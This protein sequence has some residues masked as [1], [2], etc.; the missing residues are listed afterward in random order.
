MGLITING[1]NP[2]DG[3]SDPYLSMDSSISYDGGVG[4]VTN[5]YSLQGALTGCSKTTLM[6]LQ[7][8]LVDSFDWKKDPSIVNNISISGVVSASDSVQIVP[9]SLSFDSSNYIGALSYN[10]SLDLITGFITEDYDDLINKTHT[11]T[12]NT[13]EKGCVSISTSISCTPNENLTGCGAIEAANAW[14][15]GQLG[16]TKLGKITR[17]KNM[18]LKSE[19]LTIDPMVSSISYNSSHAEKCNDQTEAG[20]PHSGYQ[21]AYCIEENAQDANCPSGIMVS[22]Y[23]GE[24]YKSG[25]AESGLVNHLQEE[26]LYTVPEFNN[27]SINYNNKEDNIN[28]SFSTL[29]LSGEPVYQPQDLILNNYSISQKTN[30]DNDEKSQSINGTISL[31]NSKDLD[32]S[33]INDK[34]DEEVKLEAISIVGPSHKIN[35]SSITRNTGEGTIQ[36]SYE[37]NSQDDGGSNHSGVSNYSV[38]YTPPIRKYDPVNTLCDPFVV[39]RGFNSRGDVSITVSAAS[40]S[41]F[42]F[43]AGARNKMEDLKNR[44]NPE[45]GDIRVKDENEDFTD[46]DTAV[47]ITYSASFTGN[48]TDIG[49]AINQNQ[50]ISIY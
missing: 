19:S 12:I 8:D 35:S 15:S 27:L 21:M 30:Y 10:I 49:S 17:T 47:T 4:E 6:N 44:I 9:T 42:D 34:T 3:Q 33:V 5:K 23:N 31:I 38:N 28:F 36:Y 43:L 7:N 46:G 18:P 37:F 20:A 41:G 39:D 32:S 50:I 25:A 2:F 16:S 22:N 11:E 1:V 14:I 40:G 26:L 45:K 13:D 29:T 24:V 48:G